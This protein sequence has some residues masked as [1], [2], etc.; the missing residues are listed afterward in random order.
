MISYLGLSHHGFKSPS[1]EDSYLLPNSNPDFDL[2]HKGLLFTLCDGMGGHN[3]GEVA[4]HFC[5]EWLMNEYYL[6]SSDTSEKTDFNTIINTINKRLY[7]LACDNENYYRMGTTL[8]TL[9]LSPAKNLACNVGDSRL[10]LFNGEQMEQITEDH[11]VVWELYQ[12]KVITKDEILLH[13]CK[14][15]VTN[16]VGLEPTTVVNCYDIKLPEKYIFLLCSDGLTDVAID[17]EIEQVLKEAASLE[18][19]AAMLY[20]LSQ[21][22]DSQDDVTLILVSN[23]L[24]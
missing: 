24:N 23:Y 22:N 17:S 6:K 12:N 14:N 8:V 3:A 21:L 13:P 16:A 20:R 10:Y 11:S 1:N 18:N 15:L 4:S 7:Y 19:T 9:L 2:Q 5:T